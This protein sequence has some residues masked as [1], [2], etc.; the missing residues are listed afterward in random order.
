MYFCKITHQKAVMKNY[1]LL[2]FLSNFMFFKTSDI[3]SKRA[4]RFKK[5]KSDIFNGTE[6]DKLN[7]ANDWQHIYSDFGKAF[8]KQKEVVQ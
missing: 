4:D 5:L 6:I 7:I 2:G 8:N 1:F 3:R